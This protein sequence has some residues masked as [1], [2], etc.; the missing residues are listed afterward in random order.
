[1][2]KLILCCAGRPGLNGHKRRSFLWNAEHNCFIHEGRA[3]EPSEFNEIVQDVCKK[4][5]DLYPYA[6]VIPDAGEKFA[7]PESAGL[8]EKVAD[9]QEKLATARAEAHAARTADVTLE[10]AL[11]VVEKL[12]PERLK[13][14]PGPKPAEVPAFA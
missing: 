5:W 4:N 8:K 6:K 10:T 3:F 14:K 2:P 12:A 11:A 9:L 1:M 7:P 13:R